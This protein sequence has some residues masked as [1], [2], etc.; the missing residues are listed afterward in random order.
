[1]GGRSP[2]H[3]LPTSLGWFSDKLHKHLGTEYQCCCENKGKL[4]LGGC[5]SEKAKGLTHLPLDNARKKELDMSVCKCKDDEKVQE[6]DSL[7]KIQDTVN[8]HWDNMKKDLEE[9]IKE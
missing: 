7:Q 1:M 6:K 5:D 9:N 3:A 4:F 8:R 2:M